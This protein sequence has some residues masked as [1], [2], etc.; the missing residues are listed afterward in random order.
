VNGSE[1]RRGTDISGN[2]AGYIATQVHGLLNL[3]AGDTVG[4]YVYNNSAA[5]VS[6]ETGGS[7]EYLEISYEKT[8]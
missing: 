2:V 1:S 8:G 4:H 7:F 6:T 5:A 3:N